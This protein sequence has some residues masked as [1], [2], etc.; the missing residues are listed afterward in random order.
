MVLHDLDGLVRAGI[1]TRHGARSRAAFTALAVLAGVAGVVAF[2]A[3]QA[4][5]AGRFRTASVLPASLDWHAVTINDVPV[6]PPLPPSAM[7][8][9]VPSCPHCEAAAKVFVREVTN[10]RSQGLLIAGSNSEVADAYQRKLGIQQRIAVDSTRAFARSAAI[11][12]V[13]TLIVLPTHGP[14]RVLPIPAP[15]MV[16][17]YLARLR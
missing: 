1:L 14:A 10:L 4:R 15:A 7:L 13:P 6:A 2:V 16:S 9:V 12:V 5:P 17:R 8:Y 3:V 11:N